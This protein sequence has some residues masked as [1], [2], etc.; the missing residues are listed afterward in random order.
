LDAG[1]PTPIE[2]EVMVQSYRDLEIYRLSHKLA[3]E[4]HEASL[5]LPTFEMYEE[6]NQLRRAAK[7]I[8]SNI[9]EGF[10]RRRYKNEFLKFVVYALASC[11]ET[12]E[13]LEILSE[14]GSMGNRE[15]LRYFLDKYDELGR[16][17]KRLH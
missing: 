1:L 11:D 6:G 12:R 8:P 16:K 7:S 17:I 13:H 5:K 4:V 9:V 2:D 14:T 3:I 15:N 10:G